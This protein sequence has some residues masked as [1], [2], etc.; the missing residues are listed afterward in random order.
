MTK[1]LSDKRKYQSMTEAEAD[2]L[3]RE[4]ALVETRLLA[5]AAAVEKKIGDLKAKLA[6]ETADDN[7]TLEQLRERL[8]AY[9]ESNPERFASPRQR[10]TDFGKYGLR[11][12]SKLVISDGEAVVAFSDREG[13]DLY[14]LVKTPVKERITAAIRDG[15][16]VPGAAILGGA[17]AT[18]NVDRKAVESYLQ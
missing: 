6:A 18:Y 11:T 1:Q 9:I 5:K 10:K 17:L 7:A 8:T 15:Y 4:L 2:A 14:D 13:L 3:F 12:A 16:D